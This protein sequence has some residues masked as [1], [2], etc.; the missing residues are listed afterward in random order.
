MRKKY[1]PIIIRCIIIAES[2]PQS[3]KYF[4]DP[5]GKVTEPLFSALMQLI[6]EGPKTKTKGLKAF[7]NKG[8][9][10]V[11]AVYDPVN[12]L[13]GAERKIAILKGLKLLRIDLTR[14]AKHRKIPLLLIKKN[15]CLLLEPLLQEKY[16]ILNKGRIVPFPTNGH[17]KRFHKLT[18]VILR[19]NKLI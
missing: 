15:I 8:F 9:V 16:K 10:L 19:K 7:R 14:L 13:S 4:Y 1:S 2:P 11:D 3:G 12:N 17:Q 18:S 6:K 5:F